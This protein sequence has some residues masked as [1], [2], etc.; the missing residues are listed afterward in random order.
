MG[1]VGRKVLTAF[2]G[3]EDF[4]VLATD[5]PGEGLQLFV[6]RLPARLV[7]VTVKENQGH[8]SI[9]VED[10]GIGIPEEA[11]DRVYER[12]YR[13]D[14]SRSR[15]TGGTGLGLAIVKHIAQIHGARIT[16]ESQL[17]RGT[18]ITVTF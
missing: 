13:V 3:G 5:L 11:Q 17:G 2:G 12:F 9:T 4:F 10:R 16:L 18:R 1:H 7:Q 8:P 15:E 6:G 14:K